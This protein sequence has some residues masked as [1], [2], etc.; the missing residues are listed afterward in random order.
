MVVIIQIYCFFHTHLF[1]ILYLPN[2][3][4]MFNLKT[5]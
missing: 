4:D 5:L 3:F 2:T 1:C